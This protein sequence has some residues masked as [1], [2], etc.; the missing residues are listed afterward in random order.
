[1]A[2]F[3][4]LILIQLAM[5]IPVARKTNSVARFLLAGVI[6][7]FGVTLPLFLFFVSAFLTPE[8]KAECNFGWF[9][10]FI[11][12][13]LALTPFALWATAA[14]YAVDVWRVEN[15][16]RPWIVLGI[17][18]GAA[19]SD[20]CLAWWFGRLC[21]NRGDGDPGGGWQ[22]FDLD[23]FLMLLIAVGFPIGLATWYTIR[24][25]QLVG[26]A[27]LPA[28]HYFVSQMASLPFWVGSYFWSKSVYASLPETGGCFVVTAAS[29][30]HPQ[31][32]GPYTEIIRHGRRLRANEQLLTFWEL[33]SCWRTRAPIS[34]TG[35]RRVYNRVGP[36]VAA[37]IRSPWRADLVYLALKPLELAARCLLCVGSVARHI[38]AP[39]DGALR[40]SRRGF[41]WD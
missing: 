1:M 19:I 39:G 35:F 21:G 32:T 31:F 40:R 2:F 15:R 7:F 10:C 26:T 13:K 41:I 36:I 29:C 25:F 34:H 12:G 9:D 23:A 37:R 22:G 27:S 14:L 16:T 30:G 24:A 38:S 20:V 5:A 4:I 28:K 8:S 11:Q 18:F 33:E 6:S 3:V 17:L